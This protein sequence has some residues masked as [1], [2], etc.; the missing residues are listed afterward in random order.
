M[1]H[2]HTNP[3]VEVQNVSFR[4]HTHPVLE[5][6]NLTIHAGE[7]LGIIGPNGGGKTT[8]LKIMLGLIAPEAG[9]IRLFGVELSRFREWSKIGYVPQR[10]IH[11]DAQFPATV[12]EVVEMGLCAERGIA[13]LWK[14]KD[15][16]R[17]IHETLDKVGMSAF[18]DRLIG[19]LSS[20]QQQ[21]VF[22]ARALVSK[23]EILF[24]DE[25]TVGVDVATQEQFYT[26][27]KTL[28]ES[29]GL[30]LVLVSHDIDV[31]ASQASEIACVN[32]HLVCH[33]P[34]KD[35][36]ANA[37]IKELYGK[38]IKFIVHDH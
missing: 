24:L 28:N 32:S 34:T 19:E 22:I 14:G 5:D 8:L 17:R 7:Y 4:Y 30:T 38:D 10:A 33:R 12:A 18:K 21:R 6:I 37:Y 1:S 3:V 36:D 11:F 15:A 9:S 20:G 29:M 23:P 35:F 13:R 26:L 2:T 31:V 25:P 27:L 16:V